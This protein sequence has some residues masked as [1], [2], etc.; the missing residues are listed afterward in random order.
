MTDQGLTRRDLV[1]AAAAVGVAVTFP[2]VAAEPAFEDLP[3]VELTEIPMEFRAS[4][5]R[6]RTVS[7]LDVLAKNVYG[8]YTRSFYVRGNEYMSLAGPPPQLV[9]T[10]EQVSGLR[11][12]PQGRFADLGNVRS[13]LVQEPLFLEVRDAK[14]RTM[15]AVIPGGSIV[16][17]IGGVGGHCGGGPVFDDYSDVTL[18]GY[19]VDFLFDGP[20]ASGQRFKTL[21]DR[22]EYLD[23]SVESHAYMRDL[24]K[25]E[26]C[27]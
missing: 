4:A 8:K 12:R 10:V 21:L 19:G 15:F 22:L 1:K 3:G 14:D 23:A 13:P 24:L 27:E 16:T 25:A 6:L 5:A 17:T 9:L 18:L 20:A 26:L 2:A 11:G 7:G